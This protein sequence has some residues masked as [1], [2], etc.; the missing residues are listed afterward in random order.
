MKNLSTPGM[1]SMLVIALLY[2]GLRSSQAQT[3]YWLDELEFDEIID[4]YGPP[5]RRQSFG[6]NT[7]TIY[8]RQFERGLGTHAPS[9]LNIRL[10]GKGEEFMAWAGVDREVVLR[11]TPGG[12][13]SI[14]RNEYANYVYDNRVNHSDPALGST[15]RFMVLLDG[16]T[17]YRTGIM[18]GD[19]PPEKIDVALTGAHMLTLVA[20]PT[21]DGAYGDHCNWADA[22]LTMKKQAAK[23][24]IFRHPSGILVNHAGFL[25]GSFKNCY[26]Y[27]AE[28]T[29]F[30]LVNA[31]TKTPVW[32]GTMKPEPGALGNYLMGDFTAYKEPGTYY[33]RA[34]GRQSYNFRIDAD[35]YDHCLRKHL[36]YL[37]AQRSGHPEKGWA[38]AN[39]LDDGVRQDNGRHQD[40]TGGWYVASDIRKG[41][42]ANILFLMGLTSLLEDI[43]P[44][45]GREILIEEIKWGNRFLL[46]M[47]EPEGYLMKFIGWT[48]NGY[49]DNRWTDNVIGNRDDRTIMTDPVMPMAHLLFVR[50]LGKIAFHVQ[51]TDPGYAAVCRKAAQKC[52]R[53]TAREPDLEMPGE[54]GA[55]L[56]MNLTMHKL[57]GETQYRDRS[58]SLV[59]RLLGMQNRREGLV[60][61]FFFEPGEGSRNI[62]GEWEMIALSEFETAFPGH[63]LAESC[64][65]AVKAFTEGVYFP[66]TGDNAFRLMPW[67]ISRE[68]LPSGKKTG[69]FWYR[70]FLHVGVNRH[71]AGCGTAALYA[72][73]ITGN[74]E[75][76]RI[77]QHQLDWIYGA[78]PYNASSVTGIGYNQPVIFRTGPGE[79]SP[80]TPL[81]TGGVMTGIGSDPNDDLAFYP[82]WW[83]TTEY[84]SRTTAWTMYLVNELIKSEQQK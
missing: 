20:E 63:T 82:G 16:D 31:E 46:G 17:V 60:S 21:P 27:G 12:R 69:D 62:G 74:K 2:A 23:P 4:P 40:V 30:E 37:T 77:A 61:G 9:E 44:G 38:P 29:S 83:W 57:T 45:I 64:R 52:Y 7:I 3:V 32:R 49:E 34:E 47:Q 18:T 68:P 43:P 8:E 28:E 53:W 41:T 25:P 6:K 67:L 36:S 48:N 71:L 59:Q 56:S 73:G 26:M 80:P 75:L 51:D 39:H 35:L 10:S 42:Y 1:I 54:I 50:T 72:S 55:A 22:R 13:A 76:V 78:N 5:K 15:V 65:N 70:N 81:L 19:D 58:V 24:K 84:W 33:L 79:F 14:G 11:H 66:F